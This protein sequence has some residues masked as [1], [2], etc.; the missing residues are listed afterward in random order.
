LIAEN[1]ELRRR[2]DLTD[3]LDPRPAERQR[4]ETK[5]QAA[6]PLR[7]KKPQAECDIGLFA[8][9]DLFTSK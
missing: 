6:A 4:E 8:P 1:A 3:T 7:G 5:L 2:L 9:P